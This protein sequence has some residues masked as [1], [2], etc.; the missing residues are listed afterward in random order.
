MGEP[1]DEDAIAALLRA[2]R[3][4]VEAI[5]AGDDPEPAKADVI[6]ALEKLKRDGG[7]NATTSTA[8]RSLSDPD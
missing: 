5:E 3:A 4:L 8:G 1:V 7:T 2:N 6:A